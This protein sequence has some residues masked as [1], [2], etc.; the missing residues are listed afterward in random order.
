MCSLLLLQSTCIVLTPRPTLALIL[1]ST[2]GT[3]APFYDD[4]IFP[5]PGGFKPIE[6]WADPTPV[7]LRKT[8]YQRGNT[9]V[10]EE[11]QGPFTSRVRTRNGAT[12]YPEGFPPHTKS[13]PGHPQR[14]QTRTIS[15]MSSNTIAIHL[16]DGAVRE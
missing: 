6:A 8:F 11:K 4:G 12:V 2:W 7:L 1:A 13:W 10:F 5:N 15:S 9:F 3:V 14:F 16:P